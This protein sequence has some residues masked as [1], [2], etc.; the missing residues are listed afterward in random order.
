MHKNIDRLIDFTIER[1]RSRKK[2]TASLLV[3]DNCVHI[4]RKQAQELLMHRTISGQSSGTVEV[5]F[6]WAVFHYAGIRNRAR[7]AVTI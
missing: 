7:R 1:D 5:L 3:R 6:Y 4:C 2:E